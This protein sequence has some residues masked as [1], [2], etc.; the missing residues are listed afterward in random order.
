MTSSLSSNMI[1]AYNITYDKES[2]KPLSFIAKEEN[3]KEHICD[4]VSPDRLMTPS[5]REEYSEEPEDGFVQGFQAE[6]IP[7]QD[8]NQQLE[9]YESVPSGMIHVENSVDMEAVR[10]EVEA[11]LRD[12]IREEML[13]MNRSESDRII[14][15]AETEARDIVNEAKRVAEEEKQKIFDEAQAQ[16]LEEGRKLVEEERQK[17]QVAFEERKAALDDEYNR[18]VAELEPQ[19]T[20]VLIECIK[21]ITGV[22]YKEQTET[23]LYILDA[24]L[25]SRK[26]EKE[27]V[28]LLSETDYERLQDSFEDI[29]QKYGDSL[30]LEFKKS[31]EVSD[32]KIRLDSADRMVE[33]GVFEQMEGVIKALSLLTIE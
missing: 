6:E 11:S 27:F 23:L 18:Q 10:A 24:T 32:G 4:L 9:D 28:V 2:F 21:K 13:V 33:C 26:R 25:Q 14:L 20:N 22:T 29:R 15:A 31:D 7:E 1:K 3:I 12:S 16:G 17:V 19:F 8:I 5:S 30:N